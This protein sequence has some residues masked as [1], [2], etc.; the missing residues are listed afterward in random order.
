[1]TLLNDILFPRITIS[2]LIPV[3]TLYILDKGWS[4]HFPT[5]Q[6]G[7]ESRSKSIFWYR[8]DIEYLLIAYPCELMRKDRQ[9]RWVVCATEWFHRLYTVDG[10]DL[11]ALLWYSRILYNLFLSL[12]LYLSFSRLW[13]EA[14]SIAWEIGIGNPYPGKVKKKVLQINSNTRSVKI[15]F[16]LGRQR[17]RER[18]E[19]RGLLFICRLYWGRNENGDWKSWALSS[20]CSNTIFSQEKFFR[21]HQKLF[22]AREKRTFPM[23]IWHEVYSNLGLYLLDHNLDDQY[24]LLDVCIRCIQIE[25]DYIVQ[26]AIKQFE[27]DISNTITKDLSNIYFYS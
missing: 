22:G 20:T 14:N 18:V 9:L 10:V 11:Q 8:V 25:K 27:N 12:S 13:M 5:P 26:L 4:F 7:R 23:L 24:Y 15:E 17:E 21:G 6:G 2:I 3:F 16:F 1:M 19:G